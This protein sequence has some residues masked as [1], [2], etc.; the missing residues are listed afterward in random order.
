MKESK[1]LGITPDDDNDIR[2][3][4][5]LAALPCAESSAGGLWAEA[6][7]LIR[8]IIFAGIVAVL[9]VVF[10]VQPVRVEGQSM[11]PRLLDQD[12]IFVNKFIY[13]LREWLVARIVAAVG[14]WLALRNRFPRRPVRQWHDLSH[15]TCGPGRCRLEG[16]LF[17]C[18]ERRCSGARS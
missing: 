5:D 17:A 16:R 13:P 3:I 9:I 15:D 7:S 11:M 12:R 1:Y 18:R 10:V 2:V 8:D 6:R 14:G 4:H